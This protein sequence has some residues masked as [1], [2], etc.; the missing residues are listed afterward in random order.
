[1]QLLLVRHAHAERNA[2]TDAQRRLTEKGRRQ[3]ERLARFLEALEISPDRILTSPFLRAL[4]T[5]EQLGRR[6]RPREGVQEERALASGMR[7]EEGCN[8]L[9]GCLGDDC[10]V[11]VG[12]EP[13]CSAFAALLTGMESPE[14]FTMKKAACAFFHVESARRGGA[15]LTALV[16]PRLLA[17]GGF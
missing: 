2:A 16:P 3:A 8:L 14:G 11:F 10:V 17:D 13:D 4:E 6:L 1:M 12:H 5:A 15:H 7:P 9:S